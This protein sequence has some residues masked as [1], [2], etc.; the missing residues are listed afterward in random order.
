E[1]TMKL[2]P[3][4]DLEPI[5]LLGK[6]IPLGQAVFDNEQKMVSKVVRKARYFDF[7]N[8]TTISERSISIDAAEKALVKSAEFWEN[9]RGAPLSRQEK[10]VVAASDTLVKE[11]YINERL[12]V[13]TN[14]NFGYLRL[15]LFTFD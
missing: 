12:E 14:F 6:N 5:T 4:N 9:I 3:L 8:Q 11:K 2:T 1:T 10:M 15:G 7:Q 13:I